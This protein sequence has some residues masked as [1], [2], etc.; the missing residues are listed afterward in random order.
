M[1]ESNC[2][3][4]G[5]SFS[6]RSLYDLN[7]AAYCASCVQ[8]A[9]RQAK[10]RGQPSAYAPLINKSICARCNTYI[11]SA[12]DAVQIGAL[13]FCAKCGPLIKDWDYPQWLKLSLAALLLLL[14]VALAHGRKYFH[15]GREM[16]V[17]EHLVAKGHYTESLPHLQETLRIAP[18]S[19][20]A[21]LLTAKAALLSGDVE[22]ASKALQAH[23]GG[24]FEDANDNDFREVESLWN[25][26]TGALTK[27]D[28]ASKL[29]EQEGKEIEAARLM[30]EAAAAYPEAHGLAAAAEYYDSGAAFLRKDYDTFVAITRKQWNEHPSA[31]TA[32]GLA[33][34]LACKFAATG[35]SGYRQQSEEMLAKSQQMAQGDA[36]A[37]K[38]LE[39]YLPRIRYRLDTRQIITR[40]EYDRRFRSAE[41]SKK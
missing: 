9:A 25:R 40:Q 6:I 22:T 20:K 1:S 37:L 14:V 35:D 4:C 23:S 31:A 32:A 18:N 29:E 26:A 7:G 28:Q 36:Q 17:G 27:A 19:D 34:S 5:K 10:E 13:R 41:T 39:E 21:V 3:H 2:T 33:S 15:A 16:Y 8:D 11:G 24:H 30:H 12:P 38:N